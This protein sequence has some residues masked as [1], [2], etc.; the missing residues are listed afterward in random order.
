MPEKKRSCALK[1]SL[2]MK[3]KKEI[4]ENYYAYATVGPSDIKYPRLC[5]L[6]KR[7]QKVDRKNYRYFI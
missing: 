2:R 5:W 7:S 3:E 6:V 1:K 4:E